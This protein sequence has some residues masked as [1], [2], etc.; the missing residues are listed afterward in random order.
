MLILPSRESIPASSTGASSWYTAKPAL[1][2]T[3]AVKSS[4]ASHTAQTVHCVPPTFNALKNTLNGCSF[5]LDEDI[6]AKTWQQPREFHV[7]EIHQ[8]VC[9]WNVCF[10]VHGYSS[11]LCRKI[12]RQVLFEQASYMSFSTEIKI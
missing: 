6:K 9:K 12:S 5:L 2:M 11:P 3:C 7:N 10:S 4:V 8:L 1:S